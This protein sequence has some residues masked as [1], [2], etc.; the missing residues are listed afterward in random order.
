MMTLQE[1]AN[2]VNKSIEDIIELGKKFD[3]VFD[4]EEY[5]L[6]EEEI[7]I[8]DNNLGLIGDVKENSETEVLEEEKVEEIEEV[9]FF[10]EKFEK[11]E[12]SKVKKT[13]TK[14]DKNAKISSKDRKKMYTSKEKLVENVIEQE[15]VKLEKDEIAYREGMSVAELSEALG[16]NATGVIKQLMMQ[17]IMATINNSL[18]LAQVEAIAIEYDKMVVEVK[19][20][21]EADFED[22]EFNDDEANLEKRAPIITIMGH[23]DH[24]KTTLLDTLRTANVVAGEAGGITQHIGAYQIEHKNDKLT[25]LDT[26]GHEAFTKMRARGASVTD[27]VIIVVAADDGVKPQ[28]VEAID[29]AKASKSPLIIAVNKMDLPAANPDRVKQELSNYGVLC[30]EWGGDV[31]FTEISAK[32]GQ[33]LDELLD[34][35]KLIAEMEDLKANPSRYAMGTVVE[36]RVDKGKGVVSTILVQNGTLRLGDPIVVGASYGRVRTMHDSYGA[37]LTHAGPSTPVEITGISEAPYAGDK[38]MAFESEKKAKSISN[39]RAVALKER[40]TSGSVAVTLDTLFDKIQEQQLKELPILLKADVQGSVEAV[41][42]SI[43]K[44][45][46]GDV[47][48]NVVRASVGAI[49]ES[50]VLLAAASGAIIIGFNVRPNATARQKAQEDGVEIRNYNIIYKVVEDLEQ[51]MKGLLDPEYEEVILGQVEV[52]ET[53]K[54]SKIGTVA[55][56]YVTDGLIKS[57]AQIRLIRDGV[58]V[59]EGELSSLKRFKDDAKEVKNGYECGLTIKNFNDIKIGDIVE[60]YEMKQIKVH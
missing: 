29:H 37:E 3:L 54:V 49:T 2:D 47:V 57:D 26:P 8:L 38:F 46:I 24:G 43:E 55:G 45:E 58:V 32:F 12:E 53:I 20:V 15:E 39:E 59:F 23:V 52:R 27:I 60:G 9:E 50:D 7:I 40:N 41:K 22:I 48:I 1:Y 10:E 14:K 18:T 25:F 6:N 35:I 44:L 16:V 31:I 21:T 28:T 5:M 17:G 30:E 42:N 56:C 34:N 51:A 11:E 36:A 4:D 19:D 13:K 33:G